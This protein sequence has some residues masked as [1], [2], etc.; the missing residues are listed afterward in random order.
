MPPDFATRQKNDIVRD[1]SSLGSLIFYILLC[2]ALLALKNYYLLK[3]LAI[4]VIAIYAI[5]ILI[6]TFYFKERPVKLSHK[7]YIERLDASSF[8]S[9]HSARISFLGAVLMKY[10]NNFY[11]SA[12]AV[13]IAF[14]VLFS[15]IYLK[16]H[17]IKDISAGVVLGMLVYFGV[18]LLVG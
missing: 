11:F 2:I 15:R 13:L 1:V 5:V 10:Y 16:K 18:N 12:L 9:L 6:R 17:D 7:N 4:G 8:P 14:G 3:R